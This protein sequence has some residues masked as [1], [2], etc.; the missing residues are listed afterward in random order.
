MG[1]LILAF[2]H[3]LGAVE[4]CNTADGVLVHHVC[5]KLSAPGESCVELCNGNVDRHLT[6]KGA[7]DSQVVHALDEGYNLKASYFDGL[8]TPCHTSW[9]PETLVG[10]EDATVYSYIVSGS[11]DGHGRWHCFAG[12][13][14]EAASTSVR[15]EVD[16]AST[17]CPAKQCQR[18][19]PSWLP[20]TM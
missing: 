3:G 14:V 20:E 8:D 7:S 13:T 1:G 18:P 2:I 5:W 12:Q 6:I 11:H 17:V 9:L 10:D 4:R 15:T 16:A 19:W